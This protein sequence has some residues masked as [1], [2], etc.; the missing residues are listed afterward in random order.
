MPT[1]ARDNPF[2]TERLRQVRYRLVGLTW[3]ELLAR[4]ETLRYRVALVGPHGSGKTTLLEDL[5][6]HLHQRGFRT[7]LIR[8]TEDCPKLDRGSAQRVFT[9]LSPSDILL[10]DGAEQLNPLAWLW[11]RWRTRTAGGLIITTHRPGRLPTLL[12]CSTSADLLA[13]I[14]AELLASPPETLRPQAATLFA[15][16]HG[17]LRNAL[18]DWYDLVAEEEADGRALS[19]RDMR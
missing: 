1:R 15:K 17:N 10:F 7:R 12:Q 6:P 13:E 4:C 5:A 8:L 2:R 16:H 3:P 19:R 18:R 14:A 9:T 11:F